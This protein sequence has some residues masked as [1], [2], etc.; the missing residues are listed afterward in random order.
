MASKVTE[1]YLETKV[2]S[3]GSAEELVLLTEVGYLVVVFLFQLVDVSKQ[4]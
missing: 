1:I 4:I 3:Q 2:N